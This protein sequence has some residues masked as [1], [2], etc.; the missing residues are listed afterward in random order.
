[1]T[2]E[3]KPVAQ[4]NEVAKSVQKDVT[5]QVNDSLAKLQKEGLI[6]PPNYIPANALKSAFFAM[7]NSP[8]G[9]LLEKCTKTSIAN[10]LLDMTVQGL[11][12]A[13]TQCY[14]VPYGDTL[15][16]TRSYFGTQAVMKRLSNVKDIYANVIYDGDVFNYENRN[17]RDYLVEH[18]TELKNR[19][20]TIIGAYAVVVQED[21]DM[22]ITVMTKKEIDASWSQAKTK[23]VQ[24][25]FPQ[26]MAKRTVINRAAKAYVNTS[27]DSDI[28]IESINNTTANEYE[29]DRIDKNG[30]MDVEFEIKENANKEE[31]V[32][33][34]QP[35][36]QVPDEVLQPKQVKESKTSKAVEK[37]VDTINESEDGQPNWNL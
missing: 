9:N 36:K 7:T 32:L 11:S 27:D 17:G 15:K 35:T 16:M 18:K 1:M 14:F 25:K 12:P 20:N 37:S 26:E 3:T 22:P 2:T 6:L 24:Q 21:G 10:A 28:L 8:N 33:E 19:D 4:K 23:N 34:K 5:E 31:F 30:A 13:K 29:D